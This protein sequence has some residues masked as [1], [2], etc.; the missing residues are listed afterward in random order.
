MVEMLC[1]RDVIVGVS[2]GMLRWRNEGLV[3]GETMRA[4]E[5]AWVW[6]WDDMRAAIAGR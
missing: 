6:R 5:R 3:V 2:L 1:W 4:R